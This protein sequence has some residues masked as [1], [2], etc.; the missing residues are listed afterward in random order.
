MPIVVTW[1]R[2]V[3]EEEMELATNTKLNEPYGNLGRYSATFIYD[4]SGDVAKVDIMLHI[5]GMLNTQISVSIM[6]FLWRIS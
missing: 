6:F 4:N 3:G 5:E 2:K 1:I